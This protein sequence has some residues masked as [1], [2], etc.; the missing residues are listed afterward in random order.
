M[1]KELKIVCNKQDFA[2][3][4]SACTLKSGCYNCAL[5]TIC[6]VNGDCERHAAAARL[7]ELCVITQEKEDAE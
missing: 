2:A 4:I 3:I 6:D 1:S 5:E 7:A